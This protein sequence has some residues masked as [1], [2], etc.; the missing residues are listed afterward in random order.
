[1]ANNSGELLL[2]I[3][4]ASK[5]EVAEHWTTG[6]EA[7]AVHKEGSF[8]IGVKIFVTSEAFTRREVIFAKKEVI[9]THVRK[10]AI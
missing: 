9:F 6:G 1:M 3:L 4:Q 7:L 2:G 8:C 5:Y 10:D